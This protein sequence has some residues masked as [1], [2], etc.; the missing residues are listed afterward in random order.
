MSSEHDEIKIGVESVVGVL[1]D[2][3][4]ASAVADSSYEALKV[5][6]LYTSVVS[7]E[8]FKLSSFQQR[9]TAPLGRAWESLISS[10]AHRGL[11]YAVARYK[12]RGNIR[13]GRLKRIG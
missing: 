7:E 8:L 4:S 9:I 5:N 13:I 3:V 6:P 11:G 10:V 12:I 2:E 1:V